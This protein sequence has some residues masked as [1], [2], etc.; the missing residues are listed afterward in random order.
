VDRIT[1]T[2]PGRF[3]S[4]DSD[5]SVR[6]GSAFGRIAHNRDHVLAST[7]QLRDSTTPDASG[8]SEDNDSTH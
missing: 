8:G 6:Q 3:V 4:N 1:R 2:S 7:E 5:T